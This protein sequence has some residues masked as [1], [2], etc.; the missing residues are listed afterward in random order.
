MELRNK[1]SAVLNNINFYSNEPSGWSVNFDPKTIDTLE[2]GENRRV[3]AAI[4]AGNDAI[5][6]DYLVTLS[7]GTRETRGEAEMRVT[8]KTSTLW[9]IVGLLIV[10]AVV[11]GVYGAFRY[12]GRR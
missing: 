5:A 6:G 10:L 7:A 11:A 9:G 12:Y 3:T 1:G 4:K 8:V 2:P